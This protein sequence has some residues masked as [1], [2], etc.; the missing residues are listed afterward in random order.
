MASN[1]F[2]MQWKIDGADSGKMVRE[3]L[4]EN[5]ISST[6]VTDI[7][8]K[9]GSIRVNSC[10]V[11]VRYRLSEGELLEVFFPEEEPSPGL[12]GEPIQ[13]DI[14]YEDDYLLVINKPAV[15]NTIPS[16]EHPSG[17][18]AN[19]LM[20]YY[21]KIGLKATSHIVTRLDRDTSGLVLV[22]KHR[23]VHHL[24]SKQ[25][26]TGEVEREYDAFAEGEFSISSGTIREPIG[27]K[28]DSIIEREVRSN[29]QYA[30]TH[31]T[32][33]KGYRPFTHVR[34]RLETGRT[35]QIRVHL[36]YIGHPLLGDDLYGG[37]VS[38]IAQQA[39]HCRKIS[40]FHPFR[41][42][43]LSFEVPLP[44]DMAEVLA[45]YKAD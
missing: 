20:G 18:L 28:S 3:F 33:V 8:F 13:L 4:K 17:S 43:E 38:L 2:M 22:A 36:A 1:R 34:L 7:K 42:R 12:Q 15:M 41:G 32:V 24:L 5:E 44:E 14:V 6:A 39:L 31:Y 23:H 19:G 9:G 40:F 11:T 21:E 30:C 25:Q 16:R 29:G 37:D 35:H 10:D 27:R 45:K 26:K